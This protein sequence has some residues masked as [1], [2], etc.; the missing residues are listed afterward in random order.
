[1]PT[2]Y[3][4]SVVMY[5]VRFAAGLM[6]LLFCA[7]PSIAAMLYWTEIGGG[8]S[9]A[10]LDGSNQETLINL[11]TRDVSLDLTTNK[12]YGTFSSDTIGRANLDGSDYEVLVTGSWD[13][14]WGLDL[15]LV[16]GS[17]YWADRDAAG[18]FR[19]DLDGSNS[20]QIISTGRTR[21]VR[22]DPIGEKLYWTEDRGGAQAVRRSNL[23]GSSIETI[24]TGDRPQFLDL[25]LSNGYVYWTDLGLGTINRT[26]LDGSNSSTL[27][28]G[29]S[30]PKDLE[31]NL[32]AGH[33]YWAESGIGSIRRANLDG[34]G[35]TTLVSGLDDP[36]GIALD[37]RETQI[38]PEP[39]SLALWGFGSLGLGVIL[40]RRNRRRHQ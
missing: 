26:S 20:S 36:S 40:R 25:D 19:S 3:K 11:T 29:L 39:A 21:S 31:L 15:D 14:A 12:L 34:T 37:L 35:I 24:V 17:I 22:V 5:F 16:N 10:N 4:G 32:S 9:R 30:T 28:S 33:L 23:D 38:V 1:M 6:P 18:V 8:V 2:I 27:I 13:A 7:N